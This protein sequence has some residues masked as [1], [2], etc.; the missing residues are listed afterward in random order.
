MDRKS[1]HDLFFSSLHP[2]LVGHF[3]FAV[4][5]LRYSQRAFSAAKWM[6]WFMKDGAEHPLEAIGVVRA[7]L[8]LVFCLYNV[9]ARRRGAT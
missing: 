1:L 5:L 9:A 2:F 8:V 6:Q 4:S 3:Y 7:G